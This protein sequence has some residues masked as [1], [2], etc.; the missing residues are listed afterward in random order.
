[1]RSPSIKWPQSPRIVRPPGRFELRLK[2]VQHAA[3]KKLFPY[4]P[5]V[6][7]QQLMLRI[8]KTG[9]ARRHHILQ[10]NAIGR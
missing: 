6:L 3:F 2:M 1:M 5:R 10:M 7:M 4:R 8:T 9:A